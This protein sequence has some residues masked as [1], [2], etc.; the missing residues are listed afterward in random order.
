MLLRQAGVVQHIIP[1]VQ[2]LRVLSVPDRLRRHL[3][4][5]VP[6]GVPQGSII[7]PFFFLALVNDLSCFLTHHMAS[8]SPT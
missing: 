6:H 4:A 2:Q 7:G 1:L 3:L 8:F 5:S